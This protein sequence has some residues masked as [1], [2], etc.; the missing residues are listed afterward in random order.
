MI[1]TV[2]VAHPWLSPVALVVLAVGGW[3]AGPW[4][5][6]RP[7]L[8][9]VLAAV[10]L[11]PV[12]LLTLAPVDRELFA[13]CTVGW[14][15]PTP[16]RV[17]LMANV[18]L[19]VPPVYLA[20]VALRRPVLALLAGSTTS[21]AIE[22]VQALVPAIGRS[23]DTNDWLSNTIGAAAGALLASV[24]LRRWRRR[25]QARPIGTNPDS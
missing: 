1:S 8:A 13:R 2:L 15:L 3:L 7:R 25:A 20:A 19:F 12:A 24:A 22:V 14:A 21:A 4:L 18:V 5:T 16:G 6:G 10:S 11:V 9:A 17:E 23:C